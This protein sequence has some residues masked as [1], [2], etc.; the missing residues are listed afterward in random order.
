[1][2]DRPPH[3]AAISPERDPSAEES[4]IPLRLLFATAS[5]SAVEQLLQSLVKHGYAPEVSRIHT[6]EALNQALSDSHWDLMLADPLLAQLDLFAAL[7]SLQ[8]HA[9]ELPVILIA[10]HIEE[11]LALAAMRAGASDFIETRSDLKRLIPAIQRELRAAE[12]RRQRQ[13]ARDVAKQ[14]ME[15]QLL[16]VSRFRRLT[17]AIPECV[18]V[19]DLD[20]WRMSFV[21]PA[22]ER[23]WG[24]RVQDLLD[25]RK[26]WLRHIHPDDQARMKQARD[27]AK[28][29]GLDEEFRVIR[30]DGGIRWLHLSTFPVHDTNNRTQSIG[31]V[32]SDITG[33][34]EQRNELSAALAE[35][36][37]RAEVQRLILDALPAD[38]A[39]LD[40]AGQIIEANASWKASVTQK[41]L[42]QY[43]TGANY[44]AACELLAQRQ[45]DDKRRDMEEMV[46]AVRGLLSGGYET[47]SRIYPSNINGQQRWFRNTV[48]PLHTQEKRGAVV[49]HVEITE[50]MLAE[51]RLL[52][53]S[54]YDS[55]TLLPNRLL[56]RDRLTTALTM[57]RRN[58]SN[59]AVCFIDLDRFKSINESLGHK[60]GDL[61]LL[62]VARRIQDCV[63]DSDTVS[64]FG[65]DEFALILPELADQQDSVIVAERI[66]ESLGAPYIIEGHE[67][68]VTASIGITLC[69]N[70]SDDPDVLQRNA[71][72]AMYRAKEE[73]RN[74][75]QFF[76]TE[77][78]ANALAKMKLERDLRY[79]LDNEEF[80]LHYQP[81]VSCQTG[82]IIGFEAL[83]RWRHPERGM[84]SPF[85]FISLLEETGL[86]I[87]VG[88][89]VLQ[90]ACTQAEAWRQ[91][92]LGQL[93]IAVNVSGKQVGPHL[94]DSVRESLST[95]GLPAEQ[96]ELELTESQL[97]KDAE[98]IITTLQELK[99]TGLRISVDDFGTGY[100]SLAY[101]KRFPIDT[102]KIDRAF[103]RDLAD[104]ANDVSI[105]RAIITL[106]H[107][108]NLKVVAEGVETEDQLKLL[109]ANQCD[110]IQGFYFSRPLPADDATAMLQQ[111][112]RLSA[113]LL[114]AQR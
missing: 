28:Q 66:I 51:Q 18:W 96:L 77:M 68:F 17:E 30:P 76:T 72:T 104:D 6:L 87:A 89:W 93:N 15:A 37:H 21:S 67:L 70:D 50:S 97:M 98:S 105:A 62:E 63:R 91:A 112:H 83:L 80:L 78:N 94:F 102:L 31:G 107:S 55:L 12:A 9:P 48:A 19:F 4:A 90:T 10:E 71:D 84:V 16:A 108:F 43:A 109:I 92:G 2:V 75:Y 74:N 24:R 60:I 79:A 82:K 101:L 25:D 64:R 13:Q 52:E 56:F 44:L 7:A 103:V 65:G 11:T 53:L 38:V 69:P 86:I 47:I 110:I 39:L 41:D 8:T 81:K 26:D 20:T 73:G 32:A 49:M 54:H 46:A 57:A 22:Y 14:A 1:M 61:L 36:R 59:L 40:S 3:H 34:I 33:F 95:S 113:H 5:D 58:R 23:I 35:Q 114:E 99:S 88:A 100:S 85:E 42:P 29:G 111:E 45:K 106:A 27:T